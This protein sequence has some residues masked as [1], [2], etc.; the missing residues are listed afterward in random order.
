M[1]FAKLGW[2]WMWDCCGFKYCWSEST[3][4]VGYEITQ[5]WETLKVTFHSFPSNC[6]HRLQCQR[7]KWMKANEFNSCLAPNKQTCICSPILTVTSLNLMHLAFGVT[8]TTLTETPP[9]L[10]KGRI[11]Q[12]CHLRVQQRN[13]RVF[14]RSCG[15]EQNGQMAD[16]ISW[17]P[18]FD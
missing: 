17:N 4:G 3:N 7:V 5:V 2:L 12:S 9:S 1:H 16:R 18:L 13:I 14:Q 15:P 8:G 6:C 10:S 11:C